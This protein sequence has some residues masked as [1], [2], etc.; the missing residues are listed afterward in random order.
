MPRDT[1]VFAYGDISTGI[2]ETDPERHMGLCACWEGHEEELGR[3]LPVVGVPWRQ[4]G[5]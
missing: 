5:P 3:R 1:L 4:R 2:R